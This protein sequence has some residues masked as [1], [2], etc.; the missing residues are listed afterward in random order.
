MNRRNKSKQLL[1][2]WL[3]IPDKI[4]TWGKFTDGSRSWWGVVSFW[5]A[6][7]A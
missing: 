2:I 1:T 7:A 5:K 3:V 6:G 4:V